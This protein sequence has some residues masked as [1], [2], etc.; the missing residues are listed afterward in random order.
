MKLQA[1]KTDQLPTA[2]YVIKKIYAAATLKVTLTVIN[3][4]LCL[5]IC[6]RYGDETGKFNDMGKAG[7]PGT[8]E[9]SDNSGYFA[10]KKL[11][12]Q[13]NAED[14]H[15]YTVH[16]ITKLN[17]EFLGST[18][19]LMI[20]GVEIRVEIVLNEPVFYLMSTTATAATQYVI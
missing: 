13:E 16:F 5:S 20:P 14:Y 6:S 10:R 19:S 3:L 12:L 8:A 9:T 2:N 17:S 11:F 1:G 7:E 18:N 15:G 4:L